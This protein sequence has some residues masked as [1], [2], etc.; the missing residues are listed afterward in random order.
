MLLYNVK[1]Q[2]YNFGKTNRA[3]V[4]IT[5]LLLTQIK[6]NIMQKRFPFEVSTIWYKMIKEIEI[7][8][9]YLYMATAWT[10]GLD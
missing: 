6:V 2:G 5:P 1:C 9:R 4:K 10:Q 8:W 7:L 3:G